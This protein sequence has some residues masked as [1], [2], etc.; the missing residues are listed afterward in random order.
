MVSDIVLLR[1]LP[2]AVRESGE[3][4]TGCVS[5]AIMKEEYLRL[6][7]EAG[8]VEVKVVEETSA[9][10]EHMTDTLNDAAG[11]IA[12]IKVSAVKPKK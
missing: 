5:G 10:I 11:L 9:G 8:F 12:S 1:E 7:N 3:A 6:M 4:Y 2:K